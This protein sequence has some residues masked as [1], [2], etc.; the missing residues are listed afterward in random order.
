MTPDDS[1]KSPRVMTWMSY[2]RP[3]SRCL[4]IAQSSRDGG[5]AT[6]HCNV[7][8]VTT[9]TQNTSSTNTNC[10][11]QTALASICRRCVAQLVVQPYQHLNMYV[12]RGGSRILQGR[13]SNLSERG[14]GGRAPK[15]PR[16]WGLGS[17]QKILSIFLYQNGEFLCIP[18]DI[19]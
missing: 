7:P 3:G 1:P 9:T 10:N 14:T 2:L 11:V 17:P 6:R 16:R 18:G 8:D 15:A 5:V 19:Y 4:I 12:S 13:V